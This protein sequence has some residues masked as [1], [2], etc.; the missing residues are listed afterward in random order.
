[1]AILRATLFSGLVAV[2][3]LG[4]PGA[5][6]AEPPPA[7][8]DDTQDDDVLVAGGGACA[9]GEVVGA[10]PVIIGLAGVALRR[11]AR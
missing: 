1:M 10:I 7:N 6:A 3:F 4:V 5:H 11:R 8:T 9:G 2:A